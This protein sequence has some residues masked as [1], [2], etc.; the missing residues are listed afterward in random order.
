[1]LYLYVNLRSIYI[2]KFSTA[3]SFNDVNM[4]VLAVAKNLPRWLELTLIRLGFLKVV[5]PGE[6]VNLTRKT[7]SEKPQREGRSN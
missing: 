4:W 3:I 1:M 5:F 6:W 2:S 7:F